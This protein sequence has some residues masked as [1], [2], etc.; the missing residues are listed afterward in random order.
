MIL[1]SQKPKM[2]I[3]GDDFATRRARYFG[4]RAVA[5][6]LALRDFVG[7]GHTRR[8]LLRKAQ[9]LKFSRSTRRRA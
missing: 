4:I 6:A 7:L 9:V 8:E 2:R 1:S 5:R 3:L